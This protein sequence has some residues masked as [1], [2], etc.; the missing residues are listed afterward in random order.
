MNA[1]PDR[2]LE[3]AERVLGSCE[4]L[5]DCSWGHRMSTVLRLR[6][7]TGMTWVLKSHR[8]HERYRAELNAY[9]RW[10]PALENSAPRLRA[11]SD[12]LGAIILTALPGQPVSWPGP[13]ASGPSGGPAGEQALHR[14]AGAVL[15]RPHDGE[16]G[17]VW[18]D[19]RA[20]QIEGIH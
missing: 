12:S 7:T 14:E 8:D 3:F 16:P 6:D 9:R 20:A 11:F 10:V 5:T 19:F 2:M 13:Q 17:L 4:L 1:T 15:R 18:S